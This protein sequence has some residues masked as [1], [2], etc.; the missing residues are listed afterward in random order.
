MAGQPVGPL[1]LGVA[2]AQAVPITLT[3]GGEHDKEVCLIATEALAAATAFLPWRHI[4]AQGNQP[5]Q[6]G[7]PSWAMMKT[8]LKRCSFS[9][10]AQHLGRWRAVSVLTLSLSAPAWSRILTELVASGLLAVPIASLQ[11]L[12]EILKN[13]TVHDKNHLLISP[14]DVDAGEPFDTPAVAYQAAVPVR[15]RGGGRVAGRAAVPAVPEVPGPLQTLAARVSG[16]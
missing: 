6:V 16:V 15:G 14:D 10:Q 7:L 8:F 11:V 13:L 4:V 2:P 12:S 1:L 9:R 5:A 3:H